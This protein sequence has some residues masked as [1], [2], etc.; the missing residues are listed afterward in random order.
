[1]ADTN[2]YVETFQARHKIL[3]QGVFKQQKEG[4]ALARQLED[5]VTTNHQLIDK[6]TKETTDRWKGLIEYMTH[7]EAIFSEKETRSKLRRTLSKWRD[8]ATPSVL[9][10][11]LPTFDLLQALGSTQ[12][13]AKSLRDQANGLEISANKLFGDSTTMEQTIQDLI[14]DI[15]GYIDEVETEI[16]EMEA[17]ERTDNQRARQNG[18][19]LDAATTK[20]DKIRLKALRSQKLHD[21]SKWFPGTNILTHHASKVLVSVQEV[22]DL[23]HHQNALLE[24]LQFER[25]RIAVLREW[26]QAL[27]DVNKS[28]SANSALAKE[29]TEGARE[30]GQR[31]ATTADGAYN[32][33]RAVNLEGIRLGGSV[34]TVYVLGRNKIL[35]ALEQHLEHLD[36][37]GA[38]FYS[39]LTLS[40]VHDLRQGLHSLKSSKF[41]EL[42]GRKQIG[43]SGV[44]EL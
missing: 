11:L 12:T 17:S 19:K 7:H 36:S 38:S 30:L 44:G 16:T 26:R 15:R 37:S 33:I 9:K 32:I 24:A 43:S 5:L 1:M 39:P 14:S 6:H 2:D 20:R 23:Q 8:K 25:S 13:V 4:D 40:A 28:S 41:L 10:D 29:T 27:E 42:H 18:V 3:C 21:V 35:D 34:S 31:C 22:G